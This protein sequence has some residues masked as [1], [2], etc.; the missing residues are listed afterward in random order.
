ME[1]RGK[2]KVKDTWVKAYC[3]IG[4]KKGEITDGFT[5]STPM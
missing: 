3:I 1:K 2:N 5:F 4:G